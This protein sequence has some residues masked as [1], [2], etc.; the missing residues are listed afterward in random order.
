M[1]WFL[2][3]FYF[4]VRIAQQHIRVIVSGLAFIP[5]CA[6]DVVSSSGESTIA[7]QADGD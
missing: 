6:V 2:F 3:K 4:F 7:G 1:L 5:E